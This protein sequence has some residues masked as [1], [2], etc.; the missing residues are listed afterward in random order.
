MPLDLPGYTEIR[1]LGAGASGRVVVARYDTTGQLVAVKILSERLLADS[2]FRE[3]FRREADTLGRVRHPNVVAMYGYHE[4]PTQA[5]ILMEL[6]DGVALE[7]IVERGPLDP[8][9]ALAVLSGALLGLEAA[10]AG[11]IVHRDVKPE[12]VLVE[13]RGGS[14]LADFGVA[15]WSGQQD[16]PAGTPVYMAPE[17]WQGAPATPQTDVYAATGVYYRCV[18]G[19]WPF[20][21]RTVAELRDMHLRA[22]PDVTMLPAPIAGLVQRGMAKDPAWRP[23]SAGA[24]HAELE[25]AAVA[26]HGR[27]W[28]ERGILVLGGAAAAFAAFFP[29]AVVHAAASAG[30]AAGASGA[31]GASAAAGG[32]TGA[33]A[34]G[35][36]G[37]GV[38]AA[39]AGGGGGMGAGGAAG[40]AAGGGTGAGAG[41]GG[42]TAAAG[43][44]AGAV[45]RVGL[46]SALAKG[47]IAAVLLAGV[48]AGGLA[49]THT[50]PFASKP[51]SAVATRPPSPTPS[52]PATPAPSPSDT[53][54]DT[55][56]STDTTSS[57]SS[58]SP[59]SSSAT[60]PSAPGLNLG[61][62]HNP[63]FPAATGDTW[64]YRTSGLSS[65][66]VT[67]TIVAATPASGGQD[68]VL[69]EAVTGQPAPITAT[70]F[71]SDDGH[72]TASAVSGTGFS[73]TSQGVSFVIPSKADVVARKSYTSTGTITITGTTAVS[74][75]YTATTVG[76][77]TE[78]VT[79]PAGTFTAYRLDITIT[80][81]FAGQTA[82][83]QTETVDLAE[84]VG[85]VRT[86]AG[87]LTE[88]LLSSSL[89]R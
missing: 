69:R 66:T 86:V 43:A 74:V 33:A 68:V 79:V 51:A 12:N 89:V 62:S 5:A 9:A 32:G 31:A 55:E 19:R 54:T 2:S 13:G 56:T 34:G 58:S 61:F 76:A 73:A 38:G 48:A 35:G 49:V 4:T 63:L 15:V 45:L 28:R 40:A 78:Q 88:E 3:R 71:F 41:A 83:P 75:S 17:Q 25:E 6:I 65:T 21:G 84:N 72:I 8:E 29:L 18:T 59:S 26:V 47:A 42:S 16:V 20:A 30:A 81:S 14:H 27:E 77:G 44:G 23:S 7:R 64:T 37:A 60:S 52:P 67:Q 24:F 39:G 22:A 82:P 36:A 10:H 1:E 80:S 70:Y 57:D 87:N 85:V 11:G 53:S 46:H 50:G